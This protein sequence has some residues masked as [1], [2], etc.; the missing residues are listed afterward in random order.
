MKISELAGIGVLLTLLAGCGGGTGAGEAARAAAEERGDASVYWDD[1]RLSPEELAARRMDMSW[2]SVVRVDTAANG[3][4]TANPEEWDDISSQTANFGP[5]HLP[6][7]DD[8]SG[9]SV[10]RVQVL[11]NRALFSPGI[12]DGSWGSNTEKAVYWFQEREGLP[13]TGRLD[14]PT[15]ERLVSV[16]GTPDV[17]VREHQLTEQEV[18]GPFVRIPDDVYA[19]AE[20]ECS[21]YE[22]L[23]EK[24]SERFHSS[25]DLL[26]QLNPGVELNSLTAG[27]TLRVPNVRSQQA[28]Y[29]ARV[30]RIVVSDAGKYVH[31]LDEGGRILFHFPATLG[32]QYD[33]SPEGEYR[34]VRITEDPWWHYQPSILS[35]AD[36][37][38]PEARVP[39]GPNNAVG[40]VWMALSKPHYGIHG[41]NSPETIGYATS[42]GCV[43]LTNWDAIFLATRTP[44]DTP[45]VFRDT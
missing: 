19:H 36:D 35:Y 40:V 34:V 5:I 20:L 6:L 30:N 2:R 9:P 39:P 18:A 25:A 27:T 17:I 8:V 7:H 24:L 29:G 14:Q 44:E 33:P 26:E 41:T 23:R 11:L 45:V 32:S 4:E 16:A 42:A 28:A 37:D 22:S 38:A 31:A 3:E 21:C 43:R 1:S 15:F 12:I 13:A 10:L